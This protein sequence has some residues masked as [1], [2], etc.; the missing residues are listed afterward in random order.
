M[1]QVFWRCNCSF[2]TQ[3]VIVIVSSQAA[4]QYD[5]YLLSLCA[6]EVAFP[7]V[8]SSSGC[9]RFSVSLQLQTGLQ[10]GP[11]PVNVGFVHL[12]SCEFSN[13]VLYYMQVCV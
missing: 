5:D 10:I 12:V 2:S 3:Q 4:M 9:R 1:V 6:D 8:D 11:A 7:N 13:V